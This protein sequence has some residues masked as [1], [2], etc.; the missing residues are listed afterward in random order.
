MQ[1][2]KTDTLASHP[3]LTRSWPVMMLMQVRGYLVSS[4]TAQKFWRREDRPVVLLLTDQCG[5]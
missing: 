1:R 2:W 5:W 4:K 3:R